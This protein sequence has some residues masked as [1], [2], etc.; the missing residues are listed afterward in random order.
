MNERESKLKAIQQVFIEE[1]WQTPWDTFRAAERIMQAV[2]QV[3]VEFD[4]A[5]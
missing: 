2:E 1:V 4:Y 3:E 5:R